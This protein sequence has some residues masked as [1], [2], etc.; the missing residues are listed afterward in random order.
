MC[1]PSAMLACMSGIDAKWDVI[2]FGGL[3]PK[4]LHASWARFDGARIGRMPKRRQT[5]GLRLSPD[6]RCA[7][8][9]YDIK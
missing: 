5:L 4:G 7:L 3:H 1:A 2:R 8:P 6:N 9:L